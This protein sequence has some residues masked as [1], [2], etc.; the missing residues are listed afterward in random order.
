V[1]PVA[2]DAE[3]ELSTGVEDTCVNV[4]VAGV[5]TGRLGS[6][7]VLTDGVVIAGVVTC[8]VV[9][10]G[11]VT[12]PTLTVGTV[13]EGT[14]TVGTDTVGTATD[15][16]PPSAAAAGGAA[17]TT[18][19]AHPARTVRKERFIGPHTGPELP[20]PDR[21]RDL[22]LT[23]RPAANREVPLAGLGRQHVGERGASDRVARLDRAVECLEK[24]LTL[25]MG[26]A[27][28]DG[29][30]DRGRDWVRG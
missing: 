4:G 20:S 26:Q 12:V 19:A 25:G 3:P 30:A 13:A 29:L 17:E 27:G 1:L 24:A 6:E 16:V 22:E 14:V 11:V 5:F 10:G 7:G 21:K 23:T 18:S 2:E 9:T 8:G 28:V 15:T